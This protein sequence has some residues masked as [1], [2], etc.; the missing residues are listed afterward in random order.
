M[1]KRSMKKASRLESSGERKGLAEGVNPPPELDLATWG[2]TCCASSSAAKGL[3]NHPYL[4]N[5][6]SVA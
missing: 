6:N 4:E 3:L 5:R 1:N 2:W